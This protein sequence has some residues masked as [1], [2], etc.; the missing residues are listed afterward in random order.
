MPATALAAMAAF[1]VVLF[2]KNDVSIFGFVIISGFESASRKQRFHT[3]KVLHP[4]KHLK[5]R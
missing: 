2:C 5:R 4:E 1:E 3:A